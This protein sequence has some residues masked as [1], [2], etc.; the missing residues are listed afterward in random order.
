[1]TDRTLDITLAEKLF[2]WKQYGTSEFVIAHCLCTPVYGWHH[3]SCLEL[4]LH[5]ATD[6]A[7]MFLVIKAMKKRKLYW[8]GQVWGEQYRASFCDG[9]TKFADTL[10]MATALA[11]VAALE[12]EG[13]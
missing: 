5:Y 9:S 6:P 10:P 11:A 1:M 3:S 8:H 7:A 12:M 13:K 2:G 4:L